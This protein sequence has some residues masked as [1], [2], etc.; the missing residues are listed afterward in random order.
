M[1]GPHHRQKPGPTLPLGTAPLVPLAQSWGRGWAKL[2]QSMGNV[3]NSKGSDIWGGG[4]GPQCLALFIQTGDSCPGRMV[5]LGVKGEVPSL[6]WVPKVAKL[7]PSSRHEAEAQWAAGTRIHTAPIESVVGTSVLHE[8]SSTLFPGHPFQEGR[9]GEEE[10]NLPSAKEGPGR[11]EE[12]EMSTSRHASNSPS[13]KAFMSPWRPVGHCVSNQSSP[14]PD[15]C[16][17]LGS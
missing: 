7:C 2:G 9:R 13:A 14:H 15:K 17:A 16:G 5:W 10:A 4:G 3:F 12:G 8:S 11:G 1:A 6:P